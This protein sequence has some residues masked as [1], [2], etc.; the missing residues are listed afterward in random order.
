MDI[1]EA[2]EGHLELEVVM[3][4][5]RPYNQESMTDLKS[6]LTH[7]W[8]DVHKASGQRFNYGILDR[9]DLKYDTE[10]P[11]RAT[12]VVRA[13]DASKE[14]KFFK[15]IQKGFYF[16]NLDLNQA[17]SYHNILVEL[18]L[19]AEKFDKLFESIEYKEKVKKDFV[20]AGELGANSFP[21]LLVEIDGMLSI[22]ARGFAKA[23]QVNAVIKKKLSR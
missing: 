16:D 23:D 11:C 6:F 7:H 2:Q 9:N 8:E 22:V 20:R 19:D 4:G 14:L 3:G 17:Q 21:T 1:V 18:E 10:P 12:V 15:A 13:M 5:L